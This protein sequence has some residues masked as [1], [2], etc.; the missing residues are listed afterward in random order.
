MD[1]FEQV[2]KL[3]PS[4]KGALSNYVMLAVQR[5]QLDHSG[6]FLKGVANSDNLVIT[7]ALAQNLRLDGQAKEAVT[8]LESFTNKKALDT[9]YWSLLGD[10]Y[11]Q[12]KNIN[13]ASAAFNEGLQLKSH[14]YQ[15]NLRRIGIFE[16][17]KKYPEALV[18]TKFA[19]EYYPNNTRLEILLA[20]FEAKNN[21]TDAAK[22]MLSVI[23][24][25]QIVCRSLSF[26]LIHF[27]VGHYE[28]RRV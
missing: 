5:K 12:L 15:L 1:Y 8:L 13:K 24:Q 16:T 7:I 28:M 17:L 3:A 10:L 25:K 14:H 19:Y 20:H 6:D 11:L 22:A 26:V 21:N 2:I 9:V 18:Q 4:H 27:E 23:E